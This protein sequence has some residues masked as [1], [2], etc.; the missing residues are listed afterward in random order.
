MPGIVNFMNFVLYLILKHNKKL[1]NTVLGMVQPTK[2][3]VL[4]IFCYPLKDEMDEVKG[5][6]SGI[7]KVLMEE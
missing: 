4:L 3:S 7:A 2:C 5:K 6:Q 1:I